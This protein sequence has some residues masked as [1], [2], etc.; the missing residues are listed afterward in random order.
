M[1]INIHTNLWILTQPA[2]M[3]PEAR[4]RPS[5]AELAA[6]AALAS[7]DRILRQPGLAIMAQAGGLATQ[8]LSLLME[9]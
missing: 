6:E 8:A 9:S 4:G 7:R 5:Q 2:T 1:G 3:A